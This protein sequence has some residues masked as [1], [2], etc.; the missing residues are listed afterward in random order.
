MNG[1]DVVPLTRLILPTALL[2]CF[3]ASLLNADDIRV[4]P[5]TVLLIDEREVAAG[6]AGLLESLNVTEGGVVKLGDRMASL[7]SAEQTLTVRTAELSLQA[8][9]LRA[10]SGLSV[11][12]AKAARDQAVSGRGRIQATLDVA[13]K[14]AADKVPQLI[15]EAERDAA[16]AELERAQ[17][18]RARFRQ[19]VSDSELV[20]L[21]TMARKGKLQVEKAAADREIGQLQTLIHEAE[22]KEQDAAVTRF[23]TLLKQEEETLEMTRLAA[24]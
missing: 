4:S 16:D 2:L 9:Q 13:R 23:E 3:P 14:Q 10:D 1:C 15:A 19:S 7:D 12:A 20:R 24:R 21:Q 17:T 6:D 22:L 8:A 5:V 18:A 11:V